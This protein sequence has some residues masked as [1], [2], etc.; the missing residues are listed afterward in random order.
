MASWI[1]GELGR[2]VPWHL[3]RF[4]PAFQW[5]HLPPTSIK[6]MEQ[7]WELAKAQGLKF[8][9][10]GN[11]AGDKRENTYCPECGALLIERRIF[12]VLKLNLSQQGICPECGEKIPGHFQWAKK[13]ICYD[14]PVF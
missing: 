3:T 14:Q 7:A 12:G 9:Y 6:K 11:L 2:E 4:F 1:A 10:L 13:G 5:S 8:V